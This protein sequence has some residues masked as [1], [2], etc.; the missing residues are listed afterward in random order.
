MPRALQKDVR[1][2][3]V[4]RIV[5]TFRTNASRISTELSVTETPY[6][7]ENKRGIKR[8][9]RGTN[10]EI[11]WKVTWCRL[12]VDTAGAGTRLVVI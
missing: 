5:Y 2:E 12:V 6:Y 8:V 3:Y 11:I 10:L 4:H 9:E 1:C 7:P